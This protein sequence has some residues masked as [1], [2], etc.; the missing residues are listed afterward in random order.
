M[1]SIILS[2]MPSRARSVVVV[3]DAGSPEHL[4]PSLAWLNPRPVADGDPLQT[5]GSHSLRHSFATRLLGSGYD[6]RTIQ[7]LLGHRCGG[8]GLQQSEPTKGA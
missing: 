4:H 7:E 3:G 6:I 1:N 5:E 2:L 8:S